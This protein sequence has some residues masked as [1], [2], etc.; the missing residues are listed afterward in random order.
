MSWGPNWLQGIP[1]VCFTNMCTLKSYTHTFFPLPDVLEI[2]ILGLFG[3]LRAGPRE[4]EREPPLLLIMEEEVRGTKGWGE[5]NTA[6]GYICDDFKT[7]LFKEEL[8]LT[9]QSEDVAGGGLY[10][11]LFYKLAN[12]L[13]VCDFWVYSRRKCSILLRDS[14][15]GEGE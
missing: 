9:T 15:R 7:S 5:S 4:E 1:G 11:S 3:F 12:V 14:D 13:F 2:L 8:S 6:F 10:I